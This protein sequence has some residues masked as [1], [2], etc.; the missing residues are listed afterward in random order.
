MGKT[1]LEKL[2]KDAKNTYSNIE[3]LLKAFAD[4]SAGATSDVIIDLVDLDGNESQYTIKNNVFIQNEIELLR[5][6]LETITDSNN[7]AMLFNGDGSLTKLLKVDFTNTGKISNTEAGIN[8]VV[9]YDSIINNLTF[10]NVKMPISLDKNIVEN[11]IFAHIYTIDE[12]FDEIPNNV[13]YFQL[14]FLLQNSVVFGSKVTTTLPTEKYQI[15]QFGEFDVISVESVAND[16]I[17]FVC[18]LNT[19]N[20]QKISTNQNLIIG[21]LL[22]SEQSKFEI[23]NVDVNN[24]FVTLKR[25]SGLTPPVIGISN[26][27]YNAVVEFDDNK[28]VNIPI[29]PGKK[30]VIFL[31][32]VNEISVSFPSTGNK[33][34]TDNLTVTTQQDGEISLTQYFQ[35]YVT[36]IS[37]YFESLVND[38]SIPLSLG[39]K[40]KRLTLDSRNFNVTQI[41]NHITDKLTINEFERLNTEKVQTQN[42]IKSLNNKIDQL[43][44]E[45]STQT[46][47]TVDEIEFR[48]NSIRENREQ[49]IILEQNLLLTAQKIDA[50]SVKYGLNVNK[51]KYA[52]VGFTELLG[53]I[54]STN[55]RPQKII[56]YDFQFRYLSRNNDEVNNTV[57]KL[58]TGDDSVDITV[59]KWNNAETETLKKIKNAN[60]NFEFV[61]NQID[62][63]SDININQCIIAINDGESVEIRVRAV[64]EAGYPI[65]TLAGDWSN[66]L[67]V[68]FPLDLSENSVN[69]LVNRN[70][71]DLLKAQFRDFIRS[72]GI[73]EH[74]N[75][76]ITDGQITYPHSSNQIASGFFTEER[77]IIPVFDLLQTFENRIT[78]IE[79]R[80]TTQ[81]LIV[82]FVDYTK[83]VFNIETNTTLEINGGS[84]TDNIN[85]LD[86]NSFGEII[87]LTNYIKIVNNNPVPV[88]IGTLLPGEGELNSTENSQ[89]FDVPVIGTNT[90]KQKRKQ[91]IYFRNIDITNQQTSDFELYTDPIGTTSNFI[92]PA[93]VNNN[94]NNQ[95]RNILF[96]DSDDTIKLVGLLD[97]I[98]LNFNVFTSE[99]AKFVEDSDN[100]ELLNS[101]NR[102]GKINN[103][104]KTNKQERLNDDLVVGFVDNDKFAVGN[105]TTGAFFYPIFNSEQRFSVVGNSTT[106][107]LIIQ[108]N[109]EILLPVVFEYRMT[110]RLGIINGNRSLT[111]I[112]NVEYV[113]KL[114]VDLLLNNEKISF[115][116]QFKVNLRSSITPLEALNVP[117]ITS[118][119]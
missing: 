105:N 115:D 32:T 110:D 70:E 96:V 119:I 104:A 94:S 90:N 27:V 28:F 52:V 7:T 116:L 73:T 48:N 58:F 69:L 109:S 56:R 11:N 23:T 19:T 53:D 117:G 78:A 54:L 92:N 65:S 87:K 59:S 47:K 38:A 15:T 67:R 74:L 21:D 8:C 55:T 50:N 99:H 107:S 111:A 17:S 4:V 80:Q 1:S 30:L 93:L 106:S 118:S 64:S 79:T 101:F 6:N 22:S 37:Q 45:L 62:S 29:Q 85:L 43:Q 77:R 112:D 60:G 16:P 75:Q 76:S 33:I 49:I 2:L 98:D 97:N 14:E 35:K 66:I 68:D 108:E 91:I 102:L 71:T 61:E 51:P 31:S 9:S 20:Y 88:E 72:T 18:R 89:Y 57:Y 63:S 3:K 10:P 40:P 13:D 34:I 39:I 82:Q 12:G 44:R 26:L 36:N 46:L 114:G 41:N 84:Y 83:E 113:K 81:N 103:N 25:V 5:N 100:T 86:S 42:N 95:S 24:N